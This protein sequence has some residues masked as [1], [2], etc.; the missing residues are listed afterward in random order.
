MAL[1]ITLSGGSK[2]SHNKQLYSVCWSKD[3]HTSGYFDDDQECRSAIDGTSASTTDSKSNVGNAV[4]NSTAN[5]EIILDDSDQSVDPKSRENEN[6]DEIVV[7][8]AEGSTI[9]DIKQEQG[10]NNGLNTPSNSSVSPQQPPN[11]SI[12]NDSL[13]KVKNEHNRSSKKDSTKNNANAFKCQ[14][15]A[16]CGGNYLTLYQVKISGSGPQDPLDSTSFQGNRKNGG[17]T[18]NFN[19]STNMSNPNSHSIDHS[20]FQVR[21]VYRDADKDEVFYTCLFAGRRTRRRQDDRVDDHTQ[22]KVNQENSSESQGCQSQQPQLC[23]VAG[24]RGIIK[25]VDTYEQSLVASLIGHTDEIYDLKCSPIN[26]WLILSA[27]NDETIR[28]W[29]LKYPT[30]VCIFAGHN[31]HREA[32]LSV[33]W[34]PLGGYFVSSGMDGTIKLWSCEEDKIKKGILDSFSP[35]HLEVG[36]TNNNNNNNSTHSTDDDEGQISSIKRKRSGPDSS[37][38]SRT[39]FDT[40]YFQLPFFSTSKIHTD[41]IDCVAFVGDLVLSK[42]TTNQISLWKPI[43]S[44]SEDTLSRSEDTLSTSTSTSMSGTSAHKFVHLQDYCVPECGQWFIRF[45]TDSKC[46]LLAVGN[47]IGDLRVWVIGGAKKPTFVCNT[48]STAIVRMVK[49]SENSEVLVAV[50]DDATVWKYNVKNISQ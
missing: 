39:Y 6:N 4:R 20:G 45:A 24:K 35:S 30:C 29:N 3:T 33:D 23:C 44:R 37:S 2:E 42:S 16:T 11:E 17:K 19:K 9:K 49:F 14:Y 5:E 10:S 50:C 25:L 28:L 12:Y 34:H 41:Y 48:M 22:K 1:R 40:V 21:Q 46:K 27:S 31:G 32:V 26:E 47:C 7:I 13:T 15:M 36:G 43:L 8:D 38:R 18:F